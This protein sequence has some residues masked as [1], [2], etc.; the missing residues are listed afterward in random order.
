MPR[1]SDVAVRKAKPAEKPY[2]LYDERGLYC[3]VR[4]NGGRWW[5]LKYRYGGREKL[6]SLG[7]YP[8][9]SL[10]D[11]RERRDAARKLLASGAD[12]SE[13]R[14]AERREAQLAA[15]NSFEVV[16]REYAGRQAH[17]WTAK[18][19][20][21]QIR[22]L[23]LDI[24]PAIGHRPINEISAPEL[25][26]VLRKIEAR[27][28]LD[29]AKRMRQIAGQVFRY[30]IA[31]GACERD[32]A[33]DLRD[34]LTPHRVKHMAAV[35]PEEMPDLLARIDRYDGDPVTRLALQFL[36]LTFVRTN[37]LIHARWS[38][39]DRAG[40]IWTIPAARMK[41]RTDH[42]VPLSRQALDVLDALVPLTGKSEH[43]FASPRTPLKPISNNTILYALYRLGY[44]SRMTGHGFRS[45]ASTILNESEL[46]PADVIEKQLAHEPRNRVRSAYNRAQYLDQRRAM[47]QWL[48]DHYDALRMQAAKAA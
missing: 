19:A 29:M 33:H 23:E 6:L 17:R 44:H 41:M 22:R 10:K 46:W 5:R 35:A 26:Q 45:L 15:A 34:A 39:I 32:V 37:E 21:G 12:P 40:A 47:M 43:V 20:A 28:S 42:L 11:A 2:R 31:V 4:P 7:T 24:F 13:Q 14:K 9:T 25:L 8:D 18:Y 27:G 3:E 1:L 16:A 30:G 38:E 36:A 48:A